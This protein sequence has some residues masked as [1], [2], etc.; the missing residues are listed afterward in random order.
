M[1]AVQHPYA[2]SPVLYHSQK[3]RVAKY[4]H[5]GNI[6]P[7]LYKSFRPAESMVPHI[8]LNMK[9]GSHCTTSIILQ[10]LLHYVRR[11]IFFLAKYGLEK[12][13]E[14]KKPTPHQKELPVPPPPP[15]SELFGKPPIQPKHPPPASLRRGQPCE[16]EGDH[17]SAPCSDR[18]CNIGYDMQH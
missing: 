18:C 7:A 17:Y 15:L 1:H 16:S 10:S 2:T 11:H 6:P 3:S 4:V 5:R 9:L 14:V 13:G 8:I 12:S